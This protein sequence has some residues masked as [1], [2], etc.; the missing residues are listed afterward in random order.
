MSV[1]VT[2]VQVATVA[3]GHSQPLR[4]KQRVGH[5][6]GSNRISAGR[7]SEPPELSLTDRTP[8]AVTADSMASHRSEPAHFCTAVAL[9]TAF[10]LSGGE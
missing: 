1:R 10:L 4:S 7:W 5:L 8:E 9:T 2:R 3:H 6:L